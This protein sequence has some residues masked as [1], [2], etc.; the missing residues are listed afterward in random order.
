MSVS[1]KATVTV[2]ITRS[3][4]QQVTF[5]VEIPEG[6]SITVKCPEFGDPTNPSTELGNPT[7]VVETASGFPVPPTGPC[8]NPDREPRYNDRLAGLVKRWEQLRDGPAEHEPAEP[9]CVR[10]VGE[11][12][13]LIARYQ[14]LCG[15]ASASAFPSDLCPPMGDNNG[16]ADGDDD[17]DDDDWLYEDGEPN[18]AAAAVEGPLAYEGWDAVGIDGSRIPADEFFRDVTDHARRSLHQQPPPDAV[19]ND[20]VPVELGDGPCTPEGSP[21]ASPVPPGAPVQHR[22]VRRTQGFAAINANVVFSLGIGNEVDVEDYEVYTVYAKYTKDG[23]ILCGKISGEPMSQ[24][25]VNTGILVTH[26]ERIVPIVQH[27]TSRVH[28]H[29]MREFTSLPMVDFLGYGIWKFVPVLMKPLAMIVYKYSQPSNL[30]WSYAMVWELPGGA[31][32]VHQMD[33]KSDMVNTARFDENHDIACAVRK[34]HLDITANICT[35]AQVTSYRDV[36]VMRA[37]QH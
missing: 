12:D 31:L 28:D 1:P 25:M 18:S 3:D 13:R 15:D 16:Q 34:L 36:L 7:P 35:D 10:R 30:S 22:V 20:F 29:K 26:D 8:G 23:K 9:L 6:S 17:D 24:G 21:P 5:T 37:A 2:T 32:E 4:G 19:N 33:N 11:N 14:R 27:Y